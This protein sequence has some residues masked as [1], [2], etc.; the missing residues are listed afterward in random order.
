MLEEGEVCALGALAAHRFKQGRLYSGD[1]DL[2]ERRMEWANNPL[3]TVGVGVD[4]GLSRA[5]AFGIAYE[6]DEWGAGETPE[7]R[8]ARM[9]H[10]IDQLIGDAR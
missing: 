4:M 2:L 1:R 10:W 8:Y 5:L 9:L 7:Q 6:N 3:E